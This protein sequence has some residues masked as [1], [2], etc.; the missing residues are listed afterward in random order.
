LSTVRFGILG[1]AHVAPSALVWPARSNDDAQ[2]IAVA[3]RSP[4]RARDFAAAHEV[5]D[6]EPTYESLLARDD[7]DAIYVPLP[8]AAHLKWA[9]AALR[10]GKHV[11]CEKPLALDSREARSL[12]ELAR[13][14]ERQ[15]VEAYHYRYHPYVAR[16]RAILDS[17]E[18]GVIIR[19][20]ST[21]RNRVPEQWPVYWN[22]ALGGG[23]T[24]HTG[25]YPAHVVRT[26]IGEEPKVTS[27][28]ATW[29]NGVDASLQANLRF[30][31]GIIG[32][33]D[34]S[35][36]WTGKPENWVRVIGT[37]GELRADN[38]IVPHFGDHIPSMRAVLQ[39]SAGGSIR[40]ETFG[41]PPTYD[42]QLRAFV[43]VVNGNVPSLTGGADSIATMSLLD[44]MLDAAR[45]RSTS[46]VAGV[47][48][49]DRLT[50]MN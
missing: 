33:I 12:V 21:H 3:A 44:A 18:L 24:L 47:I 34:S 30:P 2:V 40:R 48:V 41:G 42:F 20:E 16:I 17:G 6:V 13:D 25:C 38:F 45:R 43:D 31:S 22:E 36:C 7:L 14:C 23:S 35:M 5:P 10:S 1:A 39:V 29:T 37:R 28:H 32:Q 15:L 11:L 49:A 19:I 8:A 46:R 4:E 50:R 9:G 26:L 27:A